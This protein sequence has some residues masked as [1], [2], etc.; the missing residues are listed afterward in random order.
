MS[1]KTINIRELLSHCIGLA[2]KA[3][4]IVREV[5]KSGDLQVKEKGADDAVT[6][7]DVRAQE[8]I[9]GDLRARYEGLRI[10][11]EEDL[12][13]PP[14]LQSNLNLSHLTEVTVPSTTPVNYPLEKVTV[15]I[16]PLDAT[17]EFT[18]GNHFCVVTLVGIAVDGETV[19]GVM[20][21]P[22]EGP[23]GRTMWGWIG[24]GAHVPSLKT[25]KRDKLVLCTTRLHSTPEIDAQLGKLSSV[26]GE[27]VKVGGAG[28]KVIML[29]EGKADCYLYP[30]RGTKKWDTAA[31]EAVLRALG[32]HITDVHGQPLGYDPT[33]PIGNDKG[34]LATCAGVNHQQIVDLLK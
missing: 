30:S 7:A 28:Y 3:G 4:D 21:Q 5:A 26:V 22:F 8:L 33:G 13:V 6:Q 29:L 14:L 25:V 1:G 2:E 9:E 18:L 34:I 24:V 15:F 11:G 10:I 23:T 32:G 20:H 31:P 27:I 17:K 12:T 16:D 19:A